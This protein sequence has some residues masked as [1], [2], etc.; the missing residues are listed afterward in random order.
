MKL[1]LTIPLS[2][3]VS[4]PM[5]ELGYTFVTSQG[6]LKVYKEVQP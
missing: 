6:F 1:V 4:I 2:L 5:N 3:V